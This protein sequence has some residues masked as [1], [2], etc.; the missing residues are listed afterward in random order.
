[1]LEREPNVKQ[2]P[3]RPRTP[4]IR[5]GPMRPCHRGR[6]RFA[7]AAFLASLWL[8]AAG[9][10]GAGVPGTTLHVFAATSLSEAFGDLAASFERAAPGPSVELNLAGSQELAAQIQQGMAADVFAA[11]HRRW[12][13]YTRALGLLAEEPRLFAR[14]TLVV[15]TPRMNPGNVYQLQDLS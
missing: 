6:R 2:T 4:T 15:V 7:P 10:A 14:N 11:D 12:I 13:D 5:G 3:A 8:V 9:P 1:T